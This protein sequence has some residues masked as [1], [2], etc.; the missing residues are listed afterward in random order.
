MQG[1]VAEGRD[2]V[3]C[4]CH[5]EPPDHP[6]DVPMKDLAHLVP[7]RQRRG[8]VGVLGPKKETISDTTDKQVNY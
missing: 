2:L 7:P 1:E 4:V 8:P 6:V 3:T 5:G